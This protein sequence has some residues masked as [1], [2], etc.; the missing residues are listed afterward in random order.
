MP[1][2]YDIC[3]TLLAVKQRQRYITIATLRLSHAIK[4][5]KR[6]INAAVSLETPLRSKVVGFISYTSHYIK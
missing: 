3:R 5:T 4:S 1:T 2:K 6:A